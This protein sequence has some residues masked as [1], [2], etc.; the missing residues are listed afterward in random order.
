V[1]I[2][3]DRLKPRATSLA[4]PTAYAPVPKLKLD[5]PARIEDIAAFAADYMQA[6]LLGVI[7]QQILVVS[8]EEPQGLGHPYAALLS[9]SASYSDQGLSNSWRVGVQSG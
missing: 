7:S 3:D 9:G 6:D 4:N 1:L 8:D 2:L 5:R